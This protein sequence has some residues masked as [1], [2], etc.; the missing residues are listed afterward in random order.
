MRAELPAS[1]R[2]ALDRALDGVSR[3]ALA[4]RAARASAA[5]RAGHG[6]ASVI[7]E[8]DDALAYALARLPATYAACAAVFA[9]VARLAPGF[10]PRRLL[11]AGAGPGAASWAAFGAWPGLPS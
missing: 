4:A 6:S 7:R 3:K 5:Y 1:L 10:S 8:P 11:D 9:E 2:A